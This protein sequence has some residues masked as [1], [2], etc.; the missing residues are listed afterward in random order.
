MYGS[1]APYGAV[2]EAARPGQRSPIAV[3]GKAL[4]SL[5]CTR[6]GLPG[7]ARIHPTAAPPNHHRA[8]GSSTE[9]HG[10]GRLPA[11]PRRRGPDARRVRAHPGA[12][13]D[14]GHPGPALPGRPDQR[15]PVADRQGPLGSDPKARI[16]EAARP[17]GDGPLLLGPGPSGD[18]L[19]PVRT[20]YT[21]MTPPT[22][23]VGGRPAGT[24]PGVEGLR[25]AC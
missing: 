17:S 25:L 13:R 21:V 6:T 4:I 5:P 19:D 8:A 3:N 18:R 11:S 14:P 1:T 10:Y 15:H 9:D 23:G 24:F 22:H 2:G 12:H 16:A 7:P 20:S